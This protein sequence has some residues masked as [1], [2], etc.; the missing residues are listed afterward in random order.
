MTDEAIR[1]VIEGILRETHGTGELGAT[2]LHQCLEYLERTA[3]TIEAC[4][5]AGAPIAAGPMKGTPMVVV[6]LPQEVFDRMVAND[7]AYR[8]EKGLLSPR[9]HSGQ[10]D[11]AESPIGS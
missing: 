4:V 2:P 3:T 5:R 8:L 6:E 10:Q 7:L 1:T 9:R 11:A